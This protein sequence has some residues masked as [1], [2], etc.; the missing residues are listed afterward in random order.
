MAA[1]KIKTKHL[2]VLSVS[3]AVQVVLL[4]VCLVLP[5][6]KVSMLFAASLLNGIMCAAGYKKSHVLLSFVA[7]SLLSMIFISNYIIP[8]SYILFFGGYGIVHFLSISKKSIVKQI[9]RFVYLI[10]GLGAIYL[11]FKA[12]FAQSILFAVPY[13]YF[14]P[15]GIILGYVLS[16][17]VYEMV[18]KEFFNHKYLAK[19]VND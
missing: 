11:L 12:I 7:V 9:I 19:L 3:T 1:A 4:L 17:I 2:A 8:V 13:I 14:L 15:L 10:V 5:T 16:Q 18:I 6:V